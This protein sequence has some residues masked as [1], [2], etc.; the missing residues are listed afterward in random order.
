MTVSR[1]S[2]L[3]PAL[4]DRFSQR[5]LARRLGIGM[6]FVTVDAAGRPHPMLVSY[7]DRGIE[8]AL[9]L[10]QQREIHIRFPRQ[11]EDASHLL[12][13]IQGLP[14][15]RWPVKHSEKPESFAQTPGGDTHVVKAFKVLSGPGSGGIFE[16]HIDK[17]AGLLR[18]KT[19]NV[20][21]FGLYLRTHDWLSFLGCQHPPQAS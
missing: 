18:G 11:A 17:V 21:I 15:S 10:T 1:G 7:L 14:E 9:E 8:F 3:T 19:S 16:Y 2:R 4:V 5:D 12:R 20:K 6:P 13:L